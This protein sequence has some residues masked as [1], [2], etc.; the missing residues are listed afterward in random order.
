M[1]DGDEG[2]IAV[3]G[4][5]AVF[6]GAFFGFSEV[7]YHAS[8]VVAEKFAY[9]GSLKIAVFNGVVKQGCDENFFWQ[10]ERFELGHDANGMVDVI[11]T[12]DAALASVRFGCE[13]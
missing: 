3:I 2:E 9:F 5:E 10:F 12:I 6:D 4:F 7:A 11:I 13:L 8:N 1:S